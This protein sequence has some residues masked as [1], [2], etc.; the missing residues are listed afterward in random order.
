[1]GEEGD[2][3][4]LI[5]RAVI[6]TELCGSTPDFFNTWVELLRQHNALFK[7]VQR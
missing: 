1:M 3:L 6:K 7:V 4:A 2:P 5:G